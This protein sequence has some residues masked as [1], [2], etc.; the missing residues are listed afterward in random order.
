MEAAA[1]GGV[2]PLALEVSRSPHCPDP[3]LRTYETQVK[4]RPTSR[5]TSHSVLNLV[6]HRIASH[7]IIAS[8]P[9]HRIASHTKPS[10]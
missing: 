5:P 1:A 8:H 10:P 3:L 6:H 4:P 9:H 2:G 7:T